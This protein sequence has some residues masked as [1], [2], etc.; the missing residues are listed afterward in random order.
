MGDKK[1]LA[2]YREKENGGRKGC[3][4]SWRMRGVWMD[5]W[6]IEWE[7]REEE[8][9]ETDMLLLIL[10]PW[11]F[12]SD[13]LFSLVLFL[14]TLLYPPLAPSPLIREPIFM[15]LRSKAH[16][17]PTYAQGHHWTSRPRF[18]IARIKVL[19]VFNQF[20]ERFSSPSRRKEVSPV[21]AI[22]GAVGCKTSMVA[23]WL[24][25]PLGWKLTGTVSS[26]RANAV[27]TTLS[28]SITAVGR[29]QGKWTWPLFFRFR[30]GSPENCSDRSMSLPP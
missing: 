24:Y 30:F 9:V 6:G 16:W 19:R 13:Y 4:E 7:K 8:A 23:S 10:N 20:V 26:T 5:G 18:L 17:L 2:M 21:P 25:P 11:Q 1:N 14:F 12:C 3:R 15:L 28:M 27:S 29:T 22:S